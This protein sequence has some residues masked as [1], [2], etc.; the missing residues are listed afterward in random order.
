[1]NSK[2]VSSYQDGRMP[3]VEK[4]VGE[5]REGRRDPSARHP[6]V[7]GYYGIWYVYPYEAIEE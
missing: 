3:L 6:L 4:V 5:P 1:M 2:T 7:Q